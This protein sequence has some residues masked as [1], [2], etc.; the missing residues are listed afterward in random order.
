MIRNTDQM[1]TIAK[2]MP[3]FEGRVYRDYPEAY[4]GC[5][6]CVISVISSTADLVIQGEEVVS[7]ITYSVDVYA[8]SPDDAE[9]I[10]SELIDLYTAYNIVRVGGASGFD[11]ESAMYRANISLRAT[12]DKRGGSYHN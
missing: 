8:D 9:D 1:I 12:L 6:L 11:S 4:P 2:Q 3:D 10:I 5:P 7:S